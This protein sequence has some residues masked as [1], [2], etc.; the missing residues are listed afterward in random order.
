[1]ADTTD[2]PLSPEGPTGP[3]AGGSGGTEIQQQGVT[4]PAGPLTIQ[5]R[6]AAAGLAPQRG[7]REMREYPLTDSDLHD[8]RNIGIGTLVCFSI[9]SVCIGM[10]SN[11]VTSMAF[12]PDAPKELL[13]V[14][15]DRQRYALWAAIGFYV[16]G[17]I[18]VAMG[19][20]RVEQIKGEVEFPSGRH[21][22][23]ARIIRVIAYVIAVIVLVGV[24][25]WLRGQL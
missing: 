1:M 16:I 23:R 20:T 15:G 8:L 7:R 25:Y 14:W 12:V 10:W 2:P 22:S 11:I 5:R 9:G 3:V 21:N 17:L 24:G 18:L 19:F 13:A 6:R 4:G